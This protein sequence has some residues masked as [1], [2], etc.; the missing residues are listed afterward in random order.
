MVVVVGGGRSWILITPQPHEVSSHKE[1]GGWGGGVDG[2]AYTSRL[3]SVIFVVHT[4]HDLHF[5]MQCS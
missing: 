4:V 3:T 5:N 1:G 2:V